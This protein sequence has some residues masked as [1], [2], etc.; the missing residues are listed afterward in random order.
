MR[1]GDIRESCSGGCEN[2]LSGCVDV[3][4]DSDIIISSFCKVG[5]TG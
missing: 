5:E 3:S 4:F 2:V 1:P